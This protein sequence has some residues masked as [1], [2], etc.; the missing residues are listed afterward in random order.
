M[1]T[2]P[3]FFLPYVLGVISAIGASPVDQDPCDQLSVTLVINCVATQIIVIMAGKRKRVYG[4]IAP[5]K[6]RIGKS[7]R[8][9]NQVVLRSTGTEV[10]TVDVT[11]GGAPPMSTVVSTTFTSNILNFIGTGSDIYQRVGRKICMKSLNIRGRFAPSGN[12]SQNDYV[13]IMVVYDRQNN[14]A[15]G[16]AVGDIFLGQ[17]AAGLTSSTP[18]DFKNINNSSRYKVLMDKKYS[19][20]QN[21]ATF[22]DSVFRDNHQTPHFNEYIKLHGAECQWTAGSNLPDSGALFLCTL[23]TVAL[24]AAPC[25]FQW[26]SR[27]RYTDA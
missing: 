23:G 9:Y 20:P 12:P 26:V 13:R 16:P 19:Y 18:F 1:K 24:A 22:N 8:D 3:Q 4:G 25:T 17:D 10:K 15:A 2:P 7:Y 6:R 27:L 14:A 5:K 21:G 11:N